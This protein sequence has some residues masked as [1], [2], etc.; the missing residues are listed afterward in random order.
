MTSTES[1]VPTPRT[2]IRS[3]RGRSIVVASA[4][5]DLIV[6]VALA[7][8]WTAKI[9]LSSLA[10]IQSGLGLGGDPL[11]VFEPEHLFF[12][13]LLGTTV[14]MWSVIRLMRPSA[15]LGRADGINRLGFSAW[16][17]WALANGASHVL[18]LLL[19]VELSW[20]VLQLTRVSEDE[21]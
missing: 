2:P 18:V 8:P 20:G 6:T 21:S 5:Y 10:S 14:T 4:W 15:F 3:F 12:A 9:F 13:G 17:V 1:L 19:V 16:M 11:P 7:T